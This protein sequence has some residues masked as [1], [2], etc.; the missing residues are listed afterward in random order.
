MRWLIALPRAEPD[1]SAANVA[2]KAVPAQGKDPAH[3]PKRAA[4]ILF[5]NDA[6]E[7]LLCRR[8]DGEGWAFPGGGVEEG[9][10]AEDAARREVA[11]ET[12]LDYRDPVYHW[13]RRVKDGVDFTTFVGRVKDSFKPKLNHEHDAARWVKRSDAAEF[14]SLHPGAKLSLD[15]FDWDELDLA[16]AIRDGELVG[17][18]W[19]KEF[20]L[21]P[22][23]ITGTGAS[24]RPSKGEFTYRD[25]ANYLTQDFLERCQGLVVLLEHPEGDLTSQEFAER[26]VGTVMLPYIVDSEIWG[27][28]K[29]YDRPTID[30][31]LGMDLST[32]PAVECSGPKLKIG[33]GD[34]ILIEDKPEFLSHVAIVPDGVWDKGGAPSGIAKT[35]DPLSADEVKATGENNDSTSDAESHKDSASGSDSTVTSSGETEMAD[36]A[37]EMKK[38]DA[39]EEHKE[40]SDSDKLDAIAKHLHKI[41]DSVNELH[42]KHAEHEK[43]L[44]AI[45]KGDEESM[46]EHE[47]EVEETADSSAK[48]DAKKGDSDEPTEKALTEE[49]EEN[50]LKKNDRKR[51]DSEKEERDCDSARK[52]E[53]AEGREE[54]E[55][56]R[57]ADGGAVV[58]ALERKIAALEKRIPVELSD[59]DRSQFIATQERAEKVLQLFGDAA[60]RNMQGESLLQYRVRLANKVKSHSAQWKD[61]ELSSLPDAALSIAEKQ[62]YADATSVAMHPVAG[63]GDFLREIKETDQTG[64]KISRFVGSETAAWSAFRFP[65]MRGR[66]NTAVGRR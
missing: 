34:H 5:L 54:H 45:E 25:P 28:A 44:D 20:L 24:F 48:R 53:A 4:G 15:R 32:S 36:K 47:E 1:I 63:S 65:T 26:V 60:P 23:R 30:M 8:T 14:G 17:P 64:R 6:D 19:C 43:R 57:H 38:S 41:H 37:E 55:D 62:I 31:V 56:R 12:K 16:R 49:R 11:E 40:M 46:P 50:G 66:I 13:T 2:P 3:K 7:V 52:D 33:D 22:L 27:I 51:M 61:V 9:E 39:S 18:H 21:M 59:A 35:G 10:S 29:L 42:A 58:K